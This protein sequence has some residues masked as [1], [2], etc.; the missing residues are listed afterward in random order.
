MTD[1]DEAFRVAR[2][3]HALRAE[4]QREPWKRE[5]FERR[6]QRY[7]AMRR[8][9][10]AVLRLFW[11]PA[12]IGDAVRSFLLS[13]ELGSAL[14]SMRI[15]NAVRSKSPLTPKS[16]AL[17]SNSHPGPGEPDKS[18][19]RHGSIRVG[20]PTILSRNHAIACS[21]FPRAALL[22]NQLAPSLV[23]LPPR[24]RARLASSPS[25]AWC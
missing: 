7:G 18:D 5:I 14:C 16:N 21:R 6:R 1:L 3:P 15:S 4:F 20:G 23:A 19:R 13:L 10:H 24:S 9:F 25:P 11:I 2:I 17:R 22:R 12:P 8:I